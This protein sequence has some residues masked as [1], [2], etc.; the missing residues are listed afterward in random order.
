[1]GQP[2]LIPWGNIRHA[3]DS[4]QQEPSTWDE[5]NLLQEVLKPSVRSFTRITSRSP[6]LIP[7]SPW[8]SYAS[9]LDFLQRESD[10]FWSADRRPGAPPRLAGLAAWRGGILMVGNAEFHI[11]EEMTEEFMHAKLRGCR[12]RGGSPGWHQ[13]K[14]LEQ[15]HKKLQSILLAADA[16]RERLRAQVVEGSGQQDGSEDTRAL[17]DSIVARDPERYLAWLSTKGYS[18]FTM[19]DHNPYALSWEEWCAW[20]A[21][22]SFDV[23]CK[24]ATALRRPLLGPG[25]IDRTKYGPPGDR[26]TVTLEEAQE[27]NKRSME[28]QDP[29]DGM[30]DS[31]KEKPQ[32]YTIGSEVTSG[33]TAAQNRAIRGDDVWL[34]EPVDEVNR[35][36]NDPSRQKKV[37]IE[38][39]FRC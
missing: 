24:Q 30:E 7:G 19:N 32:Y 8:L 12:H 27:G 15:A 38:G 18:Y 33:E 20:K 29:A 36:N 13:D 21:P 35:A 6:P 22:R 10:R 9:Q 28:F 23:C 16:R 17:L 1:M 34:F 11:T 5:V 26:P 3:L 37:E 4:R 2:G 39:S 25:T 14:I 31:L